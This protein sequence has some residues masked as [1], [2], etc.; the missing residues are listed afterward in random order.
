M[1]ARNVVA[2]GIDHAPWRRQSVIV[3]YIRGVR[4]ADS[5]HDILHGCPCSP[6]SRIIIGGMTCAVCNVDIA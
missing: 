6:Q 1:N 5:F 2:G 3:L 4:I